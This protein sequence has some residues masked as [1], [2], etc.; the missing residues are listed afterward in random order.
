LVLAIAVALPVICAPARPP[1]AGR[2][3][4]K[5]YCA[6]CHGADGRGNHRLA[7]RLG[8]RP[9]DLTLLARRNGGNFPKNQVQRI[10]DG[11]Q[12]VEGHGGSGMPIWGDAFRD[13]SDNDAAAPAREKIAA[14][15]SY[16]E[17]IQARAEHDGNP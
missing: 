4:Y 15:V 6:A 16:L 3:V 9:S 5:T 8:A 12:P 11:R 17:S 10:I 14:V 13:A 7:D 1:T 2:S